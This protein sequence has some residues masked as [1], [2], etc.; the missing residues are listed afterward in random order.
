VNTEHPG[1]IIVGVSWAANGLFVATAAPVALGVD[2][3][4][5]AAVVIAVALFLVSLPVWV[6][7]FVVAAT[8]SARGD[9]VTL[10]RLFLVDT[11]AP[12]AAQWQLYGALGACVVIA[13][14]TAAANPFGVLVPMLPLGLVGLWGARHR[15]YPPRPAYPRGRRERSS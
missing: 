13:T 3:L 10:G 11:D 9:D 12:R 7:A 14:A 5:V 15:R 6:Y 1:R 8:R 2:A 4:N